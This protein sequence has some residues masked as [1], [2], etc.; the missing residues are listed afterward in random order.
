MAEKEVKKPTVIGRV[1]KN[2]KGASK[3]TNGEA[4]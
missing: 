1:R 2:S 4:K 3:P